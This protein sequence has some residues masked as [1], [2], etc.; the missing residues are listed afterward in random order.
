MTEQ[1]LG[2]YIRLIKQCN[3]LQQEIRYKDKIIKELQEQLVLSQNKKAA[4]SNA[5]I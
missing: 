4:E 1:N 3:N 5:S 2:N